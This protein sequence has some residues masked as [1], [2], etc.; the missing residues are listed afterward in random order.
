MLGC[1]A[2]V[3]VP[4]VVALVTLPP[5]ALATLPFNFSIAD[6]IVSLAVIAPVVLVKP[7]KTAV[8]PAPVATLL[9][10]V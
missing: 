5:T 6:K 9:I 3:T 10:L 1:A 2:V 7:V 8:A 4:A